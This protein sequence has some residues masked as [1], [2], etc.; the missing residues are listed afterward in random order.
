MFA[1]AGVF[2]AVF[3]AYAVGSSVMAVYMALKLQYVYAVQGDFFAVVCVWSAAFE[4]L[5]FLLVG[6]PPTKWF[7][8]LWTMGVA[9][10]FGAM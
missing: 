9:N 4:R 2:F 7:A 10:V 6:A 5:V 8:T 1:P 3:V